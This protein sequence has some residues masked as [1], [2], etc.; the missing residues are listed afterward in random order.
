MTFEKLLAGKFIFRED[1]SLRPVVRI[2]TY[3]IALGVMIV[4]L[5][6]FI[7]RGF[8]RE[9]EQ[10]ING[11]VG[12]VRISNPANN[13]DQYSLP[14][15][16]APAAFNQI[17]SVS[18]SLYPEARTSTFI[19]QMA[20]VKSDSNFC[21]VVAHGVGSRSDLDFFEQ[22]LVAGRLPNIEEHTEVLL[23]RKIAQ[24]LGISLGDDFITYYLLGEQVRVRKY[25]IVG[26]VDTGFDSYDEHIAVM[27]IGGLQRVNGWQQ[28]EVGGVTVTINERKGAGHLYEALFNVLAERNEEKGERY[29]MFTVEELNYN[30]FGWLD[31]LDANVLLILILMVS[32]AV[33]TIVTG[34]VVLILEK[35]RAIATLKALGQHTASIRRVFLYVASRIILWGLIIGDCLALLLAWVQKQW[36][37]IP[38]DASQYYMSYVPISIDFVWLLLT[39]LGVFVIVLLFT[40]LPTSIISGITPSKSLR[41]E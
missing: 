26:I 25:N 38:L 17:D 2:S 11:F 8:K 31:L 7:V 39:N 30:Y 28:D 19:D 15:K 35:V 22:Y 21:S 34:I 13:Y 16:V 6:I 18:R 27:G 32:V 5:S 40:L 29:A 36:H 12:T 4:I 20:L 9:V 14:L 37:L 3:G 33:M 41:F 23:P 1:G 24:K 10:K